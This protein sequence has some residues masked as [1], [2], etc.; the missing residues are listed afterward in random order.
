M[1]ERYTEDTDVCSKQ[2]LWDCE[3][4]GDIVVSTSPSPLLTLSIIIGFQPNVYFK[5]QEVW[6]IRGAE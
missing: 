3:F 2:P 4:G 1:K 6:E 5:P